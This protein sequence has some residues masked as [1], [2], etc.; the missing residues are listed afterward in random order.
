MICLVK[1]SILLLYL[2]TF[3]IERKVRWTVWIVLFITVASHLVIWMLLWTELS[4]LECNWVQYPTKD[5]ERASCTQNY[6]VEAL[7]PYPL[8]IA[9]LNVV[10]DIVV[11]A[12]PCPYVWR[13]HIPKKEKI[14]IM[15]MLL[16][17]VM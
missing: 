11:L 3:A 1:V 14:A 4:P 15:I 9:A 2:R 10:L 13:L 8:F 5:L 12:I 17:G 16:A 7:M 6:D